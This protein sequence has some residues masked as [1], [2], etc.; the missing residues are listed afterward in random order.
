MNGALGFWGATGVGQASERLF[1][2]ALAPTAMHKSYLVY[3]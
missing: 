2:R 3:G 1:S